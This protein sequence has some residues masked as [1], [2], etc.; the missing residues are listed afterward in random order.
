MTSEVVQGEAPVVGILSK[1]TMET[2]SGV[3]NPVRPVKEEALVEAGDP[4]MVAEVDMGTTS[5]D[6]TSI[7][8]L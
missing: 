1:E 8:V 5:K 2:L 7:I 4:T 6:H 3:R